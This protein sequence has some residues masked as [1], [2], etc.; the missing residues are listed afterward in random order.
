MNAGSP[1]RI[2]YVAPNIRVP[3]ADGG[4]SHTAF[5]TAALARRG[6]VVSAFV[7]G[8]GDEHRD[9][10]LW[11]RH[12]GV[13][14]FRYLEWMGAPAVAREA[15]RLRP[16]CIIERYS[17]F[18]GAGVRA[19]AALGIPALL[20]INSPAFDPPGSPR[21]RLD[22]WLP[23]RPIRRYRES[24]LDRAA[25]IYAT[26]ELLVE[27]ERRTQSL[28]VVSNGFDPARFHPEGE[29]EHLPFPEGTTVFALVSSFRAWHG[30]AELVE[31]AARLVARGRRNLGLA[32]IGDGPERAAVIARAADLGI[33]DRVWIPGR[34]PTDRVAAILRASHVGVAPFASRRHADLAVGFFWS[35]IKLFE[36]MGSGLPVITTRVAPLSEHVRDGVEGLLIGDGDVAELARA[37]ERFLDDPALVREM[38]VRA[39]A[40]AREHFTWDAQA[41]VVEELV[42]EVLRR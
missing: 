7:N 5:L 21:A 10:V 19:A 24:L 42:H 31:A 34:V 6:H 14:S 15:R 8:R 26:S 3:G 30:A 16:D 32:L 23:G 28:R 11:L 13:H 12:R 25:A 2:L 18:G 33:G 1:L 27:P 40:R 9:G 4:S 37:M 35:P 29:R 41:R 38:G 36:Y 22:G 20:E 17:S 39:L